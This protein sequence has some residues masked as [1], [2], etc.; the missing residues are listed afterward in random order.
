MRTIIEMPTFQEDAKKIW[1][2]KERGAWLATNPEAGTVI[3]K[4]GGCHK[5]R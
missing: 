5:I 1:S 2:E 3:P 4:S